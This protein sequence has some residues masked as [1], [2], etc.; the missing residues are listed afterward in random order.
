[1][2]RE[3]D[4][5]Q[6]LDRRRNPLRYGWLA[7]ITAVLVLAPAF[8]AGPP[9]ATAGTDPSEPVEEAAAEARPQP[10]APAGSPQASVEGSGL[11]W[12]LLSHEYC[13]DRFGTTCPNGATS[14]DPCPVSNPQ[15]K[16]CVIPGDRC[17][18]VLSAWWADE[19]RCS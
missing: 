13:L 9:A 18:S 16:P 15:G 12:Q 14:A 19:Y 7:A 5:M 8:G 1:M 11:T 2:T 3:E 10:A 17:W 4:G 6:E